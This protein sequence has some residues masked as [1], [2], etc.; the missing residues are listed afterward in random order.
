MFDNAG[1][2]RCHINTVA[3]LRQRFVEEGIEASLERNKREIPQ[4]KPKLDGKKEARLIAIACSQPPEG[5]CIWTMQMLADK[6]VEMNIVESV[7]DSTVWRTLK[8]TNLSLT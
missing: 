7:S 3:N 6:M 5:Y 1:R 8:K 4:I 2:C